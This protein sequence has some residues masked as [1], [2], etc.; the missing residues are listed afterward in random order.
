MYSKRGK[1]ITLYHPFPELLVDGTGVNAVVSYS[2][3]II[4]IVQ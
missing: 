4:I 2:I 3:V 1:I